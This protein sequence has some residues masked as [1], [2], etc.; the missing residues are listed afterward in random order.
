[1][2]PEPIIRPTSMRGVTIST[3][4]ARAEPGISAPITP[5]LPILSHNAFASDADSE[6]QALVDARFRIDGLFL[7]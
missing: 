6:V 2:P 1:M 5:D 7:L 4:S 3:F